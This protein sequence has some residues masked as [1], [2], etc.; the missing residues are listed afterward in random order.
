MTDFI[1]SAEFDAVP[2]T[3]PGA[4]NTEV[5]VSI[6]PVVSKNYED[7]GVLHFIIEDIPVCLANGIRRTIMSDIP[8]IAIRTE[9][10]SI[11]QC[12]IETNTSRFHNEI[13]KQRLSCIPII[14][15]D[16]EEFPQNYKL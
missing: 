3:N 13:I 10:S 6:N 12:Q 9:T 1:T 8:V 11:N 4:N 16:L 2:T 14:S 5:S 7:D 15:Q